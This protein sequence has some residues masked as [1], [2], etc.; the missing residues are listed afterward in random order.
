MPAGDA[1]QP[2]LRLVENANGVEA[3]DDMASEARKPPVLLLAAANVNNY[4][5]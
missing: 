3:L 5:S 1:K 4:L 2:T